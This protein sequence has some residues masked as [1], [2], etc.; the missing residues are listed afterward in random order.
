ML[1]I[2]YN[3]NVSR[4]NLENY[5]GSMISLVDVENSEVF[6]TIEIPEGEVNC[7]TWNEF[8][9]NGAESYKPFIYGCSAT[10]IEFLPKMVPIDKL[11]G[12][13]VPNCSKAI[14]SRQHSATN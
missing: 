13:E 10:A 3:K 8:Q 11:Y 5:V 2:G 6:K 1:T 14:R 4:L 7:L 12:D 9:C